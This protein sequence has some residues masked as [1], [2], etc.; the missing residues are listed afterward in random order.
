MIK[1]IEDE[2]KFGHRFY[3]AVDCPKTVF[4]DIN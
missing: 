4:N 2:L 3:K 1:E